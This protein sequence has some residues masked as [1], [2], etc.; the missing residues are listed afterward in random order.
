MIA[1]M[2]YVADWAIAV[3]AMLCAV[4]Q[5]AAFRA[6]KLSQMSALLI[7][8]RALMLAG[9]SVAAMRLSYLLAEYGDIPVPPLTQL[10]IGLLEA[11]TLLITAYWLTSDHM[12]ADARRAG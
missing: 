4:L 8:G 3:G 7:G 9:W 11:G 10:W 1:T 2:T 5:L 6:A 12:T